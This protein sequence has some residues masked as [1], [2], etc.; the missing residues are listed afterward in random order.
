MIISHY[1]FFLFYEGARPV[2]SVKDTII[3]QCESMFL[4]I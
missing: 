1:Y 3:S 2:T 4:Y